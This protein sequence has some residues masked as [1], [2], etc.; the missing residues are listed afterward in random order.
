[1]HRIHPRWYT[2]TPRKTQVAK[3]ER[4]SEKQLLSLMGVFRPRWDGK[5][6]RVHK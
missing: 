4:I 6:Y 1:M 2:V 3:P 5:G